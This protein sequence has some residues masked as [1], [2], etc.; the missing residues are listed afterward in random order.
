MSVTR[1]LLDEV[2]AQI[3]T[4][5][6]I[7]DAVVGEPVGERLM[8]VEYPSLEALNKIFESDA[9]KSIVPARDRAFSK[10]SVSIIEE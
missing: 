8:I 6:G 5:F 7:G 2:G 10:Y 9:Y 4:S 3:K 1:P